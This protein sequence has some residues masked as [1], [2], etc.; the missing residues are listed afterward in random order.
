M[1]KLENKV[2]VITG[3][4]KGIGAGIAKHLAAAGASVVVNYASAKAGAEKVVAEITAKGGKAIAVQGNVSNEADVTRLFEETK[5]TFGA[6]DILVNNAGVYKFGAIEEINAADFHTQFDTNVLGLLLTTQG[7]VKNFNANGGSIINIGSVVSSIAPV[8][9][10]IYTATKGAVDAITHVLAKELG[11]KKIR[12]NSI[13]PGMIETEGTHAAGF[14]GSD[15]E[16]EMARTTPLG[17]I[18]QPDDIA[19]VAVFLASEDSR[20]LTGE[21]LLAGGGIR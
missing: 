21:T 12:V 5:K 11:G 20:W 4:S 9:S 13:N 10:S 3:A 6:V 7:A 17:R 8:A 14:I 19:D 1:K 18:G 2:A 16:A 15:F